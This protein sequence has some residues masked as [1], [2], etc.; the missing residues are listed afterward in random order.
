MLCELVEPCAGVAAGDFGAPASRLGA[1]PP[2]R[3]ALPLDD[4]CGS[5]DGET[6][7]DGA[8]SAEAGACEDGAGSVA[9]EG[10]AA[11]DAEGSVVALALGGVGT[12]WRWRLRRTSAP[13]VSTMPAAPRTP[14]PTAIASVA[15]ERGGG[16]TAL[17]EGGRGIVDACEWGTSEPRGGS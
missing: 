12:S 10:G 17:D 5:A 15:R 7:D 1:L 9:V 2:P 4:A 11:L 6:R 14:I 3:D 8:G 13:A 16:R